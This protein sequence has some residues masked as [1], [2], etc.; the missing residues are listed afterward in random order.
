MANNVPPKP[1]VITSFKI[2]PD[3]YSYNYIDNMS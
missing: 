3:F 1:K 2:S